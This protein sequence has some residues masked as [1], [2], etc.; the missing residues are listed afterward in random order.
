MAEADGRELKGREALNVRGE[1]L[2]KL[3][4]VFTHGEGEKAQWAQ[5]KIG[6]LG[7]HKAV[8][9]LEMAEEANGKLTFPYETEHIRHAPEV[10]PEEGRLNDEQVDQ[11]CRHYGLEPIAPPSGISEDDIE[12]PRETRDAKPPALEEGEDSPLVQRRRERA[13]ELGVPHQD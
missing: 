3:D 1:R 13:R 4:A 8:V 7:L 6:L 12:L 9:P 10:D 5:I 11:L 2:G